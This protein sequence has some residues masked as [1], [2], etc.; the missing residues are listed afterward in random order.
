MIWILEIELIVFNPVYNVSKKIEHF[1]S[2]DL[3]AAIV[4]L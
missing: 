3:R 1:E 4:L 2:D